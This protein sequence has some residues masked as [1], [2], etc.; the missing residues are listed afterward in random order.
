[1]SSLDI[2]KDVGGPVVQTI[3]SIFGADE[4]SGAA[5]QAAQIQANANTQ[6]AQ[7]QAK[8]AADALAFEQQQA[9]VAQGNF[10]NTQAF[11]RSVYT[12]QQRNLAPYRAI[13][14]GSIAELARPIGQ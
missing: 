2:L 10:Q 11:N 6:A 1:M 13:G 4:Q 7:M 12:N 3:G 8:S 9:G 14:A 5:K